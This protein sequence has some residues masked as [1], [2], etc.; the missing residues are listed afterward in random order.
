MYICEPC[1]TKMEV[2]NVENPIGLVHP[3]QRYSPHPSMRGVCRNCGARIIICSW[4]LKETTGYS[5]D[6]NYTRYTKCTKCQHDF[7]DKHGF[8]PKCEHLVDY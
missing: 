6:E 2:V 1:G 8:C 7:M 5:V 3:D 4:E